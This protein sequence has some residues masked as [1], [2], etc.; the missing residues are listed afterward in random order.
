MSSAR[1]LVVEDEAIVALNIAERLSGLGYEVVGRATDGD[2][3]LTLAERERPDAVLM[4]I[5]LQGELDGITAATQIRQRLG[6]PVVFLTSYSE[7]ATLKRALQA[8]PFGYILKP[9]DDRDLRTALEIALYKHR[10]EME[11]RRLNRLYAVLSQVS[12]AIVRARRSED[13]FTAICRI[14]VEQGRFRWAWIGGPAPGG[15]ALVPLAR[16]G[17][18]PDGQA[19]LGQAG[20]LAEAAWRT[21]RPAWVNDLRQEDRADARLAVALSRGWG[22]EAAF[23]IQDQGRVGAVLS[24]AAGEAGFF[25]EKEIGLL[26]EVAADVSYALENLERERQRQRAVEAQHESEARFRSIFENSP[27]SIAINRL[28]DGVYLAVNPAFLHLSGYPA[29]EVV[30]R[31]SLQVGLVDS[32]KRAA[33]LSEALRQRGRLENELT[34]VRTRQGERRHCLF[35]SVVVEL[36]GERCVVSMAVDVTEQE[37]TA[38][39]LRRSEQRYQHILDSAQDWVWEVNEAG[40]Y[41]F[42]SQRVRDVLGYEPAEILGKTPFDFMPPAEAKRVRKAFAGRTA[43][44]QAFR[45]LENINRHKDGRLVILES[46]GVPVLDDAGHFRGYRGIDRDITQRKRDEEAKASLEA[47]LRQ[48]QKLEAIGTLAGGIAHDFNNILGAI[49]SFTELALD[50]T[51]DRPEVQ[52]WLGNV[53]TGSR[54][55]KDLVRQILAFS[56][57]GGQDR[58][59]MA[60]QL[61]VREAVKLLRSTLPATLEV[62]F[63]FGEDLPLIL[64]DPTQMHQVLV[65]LCTNAAHAMG[66]RAGRLEITLTALTPEADFRCHHPDL[67]ERKYV[68][69]TVRDSGHGMDEAVVKRIFEPFFTTKGPGEGTGL[70]LAVVHGIVRGHEGAI[71]VA[72]QPGQGSV[73]DL[74]FPALPDE[75]GRL[76]ELALAP[77]PK[78]RGERVLFVDDEPALVQAAE[79]ELSRLGYQPVGQ[80]NPHQA[81]KLFRAQPDDFD[82]VVTDLTMP[83]L[84]GVELA[85]ALLALRPNLP[86]LLT[87]GFAKTW[88]PEALRELGIREVLA[89]PLEAATLAQALDAVLHAPGAS[90]DG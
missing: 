56:R 59:P 79:V 73:F 75:P 54:R 45:A 9:F 47:Q 66:G 31:S 7:S 77:R 62:H 64:A 43:Q 46:S 86:I 38:A 63:E 67:G 51:R 89:K 41:T 12:Q 5:R 42:A 24:V 53:L 28:D 39:A 35:S 52:D 57:R 72:S 23:P 80:S 1:I 76:D 40:A 88:T 33:R 70:G 68:R 49:L 61:I 13:L 34:E 30:G 44:R 69:L 32:P 85:T 82:L 14:A 48:T 15:D 83:G 65:N 4:D 3:A 37:R 22:A 20:S 21:G 84:T 2:G 71:Y 36:G 10:A 19:R 16:W 27:Y 78:G 81:L 74:F 17:E 18:E 55:A 60:L 26:T 6:L 90:A 25:Q 8:E 87:T 11:I 50:E 29:D 58:R